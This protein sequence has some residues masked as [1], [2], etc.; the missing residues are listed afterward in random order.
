MGIYPASRGFGYAIFDRKGQILNYDS[1]FMSPVINKDCLKKI[2]K[3]VK[4]WQPDVF[5]LR[6]DSSP[7]YKGSERTSRLLADIRRMAQDED[8]AVVEYSRKDIVTTFERFDATKKREIAEIICSWFPFLTSKLPKKRKY[9]GEGPHH[10]DSL[11]D[12]I[13]LVCTYEH[14]NT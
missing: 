7:D 1:P 12:A 13:S 3:Q 8:I 11:F 4:K 9:K 2:R 10:N 6:D 5:V 14:F